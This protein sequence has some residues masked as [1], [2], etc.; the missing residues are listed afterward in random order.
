MTRYME[1]FSR[2]SLCLFAIFN[3]TQNL[4]INWVRSDPRT[5]LNENKCLCFSSLSNSWWYGEIRGRN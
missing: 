4:F 2:L 1:I 5:Y 3:R